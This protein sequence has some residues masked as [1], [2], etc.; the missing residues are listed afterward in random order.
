MPEFDPASI[1]P[2]PGVFNEDNV[3]TGNVKDPAKIE[4]KVKEALKK[5]NQLVADYYRKQ[6]TGEADY[7]R[8]VQNKAALSASTGRVIAIGYLGNQR[9]L[10]LGINGVTEKALLLKFWHTYRAARESN[11][12][13]VGFCIKDFDVPFLAQRS[14]ILGLDVPRTLLTA[15]G[16]LDPCFIDLHERWKCGVRGRGERGASTLDAVCQ[17]LG[18]PG[19]VDGCTGADFARLLRSEKEEERHAAIAYLNGDL[20]SASSVAERLGV[21]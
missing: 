17:A 21:V 5:H 7:W 12:P 4:E 14:W 6:S 18:L 3:K 1:G 10:H 13:M 8:D 19:K 20:D 9:T 15:S 11:R 2:H 16:Y